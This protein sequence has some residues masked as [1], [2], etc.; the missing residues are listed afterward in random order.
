M[1]KTECFDLSSHS[2]S[3][4]LASGADL[5]LIGTRLE[6][7]LESIRFLCLFHHLFVK[8]GLSIGHI[9]SLAKQLLP[10]VRALTDASEEVEI[11]L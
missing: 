4:C 9:Y 1:L 11:K 3:T 8:K 7:S 10:P 6:G 2:A 5:Y